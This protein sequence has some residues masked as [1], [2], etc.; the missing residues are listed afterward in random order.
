M[1]QKCYASNC[2]Y[3]WAGWCVVGD[4]TAG[5]KFLISRSCG[6]RSYSKCRVQISSCW[7]TCQRR[8]GKCSPCPGRPIWRS[9]R[10]LPG[11]IYQPIST[12]VESLT[13]RN[14]CKLYNYMKYKCKKLATSHDVAKRGLGAKFLARIEGLSISIYRLIIWGTISGNC[15]LTPAV[16]SW[17]FPPHSSHSRVQLFFS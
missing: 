5:S 10:R 3:N 2:R 8:S 9:Y 13:L 14:K 15:F 17:C 1:F 7:V 16:I 4:W 12:F 11:K 6:W